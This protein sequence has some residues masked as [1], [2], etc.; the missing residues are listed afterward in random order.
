V[1]LIWSLSFLEVLGEGRGGGFNEMTKEW[2]CFHTWRG[3]E[4]GHKR[5]Q[6]D[7][8]EG[9]GDAWSSGIVVCN[10]DTSQESK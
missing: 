8:W 1:I 5:Y 2:W 4:E 7:R 3:R 9:D 10:G 6:R